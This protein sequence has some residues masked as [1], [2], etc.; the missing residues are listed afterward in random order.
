MMGNSFVVLPGM[1]ALRIPIKAFLA[2]LGAIKTNTF[3]MILN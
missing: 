2:L 1:Q 3:P